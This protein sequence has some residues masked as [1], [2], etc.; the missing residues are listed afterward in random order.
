M[1]ANCG[2]MEVVNRGIMDFS[3]IIIPRFANRGIMTVLKSII[4]RFVSK[5]YDYGF[6]YCHNHTVC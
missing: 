3:T 4:P 2:I 1:D 6:Q 5:P